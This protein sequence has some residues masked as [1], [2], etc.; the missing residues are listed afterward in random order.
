MPEVNSTEKLEMDA[1][2]DI[3]V[4]G[5]VTTVPRDTVIDMSNVTL[6]IITILVISTLTLILLVHST[7]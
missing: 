3:I 4:P 7:I 2:A 1:D 5:S 6:Q